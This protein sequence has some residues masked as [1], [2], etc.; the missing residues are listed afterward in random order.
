MASTTKQAPRLKNYTTIIT[1]DESITII[2]RQLSM[3]KAAR[4]IFEGDDGEGNPTGISFVIKITGQPFSFRIPARFAQVKDLVEQTNK[5]AGVQMSIARL[6]EQ[7]K[8]TA[9]ANIKDWVAAQM[10]LIDSG[11]VKI[12]EVFFPYMVDDESGQTVFESFERQL[13]LPAP[14]NGAR[15]AYTIQQEG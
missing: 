3:H 14:K 4:I 6:H 12:E 2:R 10:A 5:R 1:V 7:A 15:A 13:A 8:R 9:W 11:A